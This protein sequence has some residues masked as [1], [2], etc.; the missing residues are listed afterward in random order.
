MRKFEFFVIEMPVNKDGN[1][2]E[3]DESKVVETRW[4]I[5]D[6]GSFYC[7]AEYSTK[8]EALYRCDLLNQSI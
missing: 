7:E 1:G 3:I 2:P 5:W 4:Q 6:C 8:E